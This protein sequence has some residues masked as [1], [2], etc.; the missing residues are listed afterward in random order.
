MTSMKNLP[1]LSKLVLALAVLLPVHFVV[2]A[3]GTKIGLWDW[4]MGLGVLTFGAGL[5]L[6]SIVALIA[7]VALI[8]A[9]FKKPR[10]KGAMIAA[11]IGLL[12]PG[13]IALWGASAAGIAADNP[14]HDV[15][16][17]TANPPVFS[18]ATVAA[19]DAE[20]ANPL[21]DY[22]VPLNQ[23]E[24][25][26]SLESDNPLA[27]QSHTEIIAERYGDLLPLD[28]DGAS[29]R[30]VMGIAMEVMF[31]NGIR[32]ITISEDE[33]SAEGVFTSFWY[34]FEDDFVIRYQNG[35]LDFRSVSRVGTSDLG[36]NATRIAKVREELAARL[37]E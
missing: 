1:W 22:S 7:L 19:R 37:A 29:A 15:S 8:L 25:W 16:T 9:V 6:V 3:L 4:Q 18:A 5:V 35:Q 20:D 26:S 36:A 2:A 17:D 14:I 13:S 28:T 31:A 33:T 34:E 30:D 24:S 10:R 23:L 12:V 27:S 11:L 21:N 32:D